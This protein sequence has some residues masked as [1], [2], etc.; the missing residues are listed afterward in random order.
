MQLNDAILS[1]TGGTN[2]NDGLSAFYSRTQNESLQDAESRWLKSKG[3]TSSSL[4]DMWFEYLS[5]IG[6]SGS[7]SD[8]KLNYW[9]I[10]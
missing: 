5:G 1:A 2:I 10:L 7:L 8:M 9:S 4:N 3:V 6:F